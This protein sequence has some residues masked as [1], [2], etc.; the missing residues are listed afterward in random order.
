LNAAAGAPATP[1]RAGQSSTLTGAEAPAARVLERCYTGP[2]GHP[3]A[4][5][6]FPKGPST[7]PRSGAG[8]PPQGVI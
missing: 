1:R 4:P 8:A 5:T 6:E 3:I 2:G 7:A